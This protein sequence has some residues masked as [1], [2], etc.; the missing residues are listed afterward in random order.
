MV[1]ALNLWMLLFSLV[2]AGI[3]MGISTTTVMYSW[4]LHNSD[5]KEVN[6]Y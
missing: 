6:E 5:L 1:A 2:L 4:N 3:G